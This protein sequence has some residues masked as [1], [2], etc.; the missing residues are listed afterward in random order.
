[1]LSLQDF[2]EDKIII[3]KDCDY[4]YLEHFLKELNLN[5]PYGEKKYYWVSEI[6]KKR[7]CFST[8]AIDIASMTDRPFVFAKPDL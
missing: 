1:M 3:V 5:I 6:R 7:M 2:Y 4:S 8:N